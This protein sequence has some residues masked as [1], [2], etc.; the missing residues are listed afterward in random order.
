MVTVVCFVRTRYPA[1]FTVSQ[2]EVGR[3]CFSHGFSNAQVPKQAQPNT[4]L[5]MTAL[6]CR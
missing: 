4:A 2:V 3:V 6:A 5:Q 1:A